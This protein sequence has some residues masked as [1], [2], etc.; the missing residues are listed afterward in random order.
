MSDA[1]AHEFHRQYAAPALKKAMEDLCAR[2]GRT[3]ESLEGI[4]LGEAYRLAVRTYGDDLPEFWRIWNS[5][6][7]APDDPAP[8]GEL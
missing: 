1:A 6:N 4:T 8:M 5:W 2:T 3:L 7:E